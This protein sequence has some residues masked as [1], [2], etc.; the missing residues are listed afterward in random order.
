MRRRPLDRPHALQTRDQTEK[1]A[2]ANFLKRKELEDQLEEL[3]V[4]RLLQGSPWPLMTS[5][6]LFDDL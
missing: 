6:D 4:R 2:H 1:K 5:D 3:E